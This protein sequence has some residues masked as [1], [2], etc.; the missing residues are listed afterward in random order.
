MNISL[1][2]ERL[3]TNHLSQGMVIKHLV[4][5]KMHL[6][7]RRKKRKRCPKKKKTNL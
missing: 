5:V 6:G 1:C 3:A 7:G 2:R 4:S